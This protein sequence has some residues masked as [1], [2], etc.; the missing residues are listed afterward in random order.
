MH[1]LETPTHTVKDVIELCD[2]HIADL[3]HNSCL[4]MASDALECLER[5]YIA[6]GD[7]GSLHTPPAT[8]GDADTDKLLPWVYTQKMAKTG[9]SARVIYDKIKMQAR[10]GACAYCEQSSATTLDHFL[11]KM[12]S[13]CFAITPINLIPACKDCNTNKLES[14]YSS[15]DELIIHPYYDNVENMPWLYAQFPSNVP[16]LEY[17]VDAHTAFSPQLAQK[18]IN[19]FNELKLSASYS[20]LA[21]QAFADMRLRLVRLHQKKGTAGVQ[22]YLLEEFES[23]EAAS[24]NS[25][26][27]AMFRALHQSDWFCQGG[28]LQIPAP[29]HYEE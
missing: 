3:K 18:I 9:G 26:K 17:Y 23:S 7:A 2:G 13:P 20:C 6:A 16:K 28:F 19:T 21:A 8:T 14:R 22:E 1:Y 29:K 4:L 24:R 5:E 11:S 25:W 27:T 15:Q 10:D 12:K